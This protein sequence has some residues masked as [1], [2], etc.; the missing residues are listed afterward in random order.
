MFTFLK[1]AIS[2][3]AQTGSVAESSLY[4][5]R[6]MTRV[7]NFR[8]TIRVVELGAGTGSITK[9]VLSRMNR[10]SVITSFEINT[11]LFRKFSELNDR[12]LRQI[13]DN[14]VEL[15]SYIPSQSADYIISGL[16]LANIDREQKSKIIQTCNKILKPGG[17]YIQFQYSLNDIRLLKREFRSVSCGFTFLNLPPAFVYYAKK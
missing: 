8:K 12:R 4:L 15:D 6:R 7:I 13:N 10:D 3:L 17:Y 16:P 11:E 5:S 14:A 1:A 2:N 9:H